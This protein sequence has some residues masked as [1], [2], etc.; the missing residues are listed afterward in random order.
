ME[1]AKKARPITA[2]S[3]Y[4][5]NQ[6]YAER[7]PKSVVTWILDDMKKSLIFMKINKSGMVYNLLSPIGNHLV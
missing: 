1:P 2:G 4:L 7:I 6:L 5:Y 3:Y